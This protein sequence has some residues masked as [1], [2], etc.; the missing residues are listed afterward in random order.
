MNRSPLWKSQVELEHKKIVCRSCIDLLMG[1]WTYRYTERY[2]NLSLG[3]QVKLTF[4]HSIF[5]KRSCEKQIIFTKLYAR[6]KTNKQCIK[7]QGTQ[8]NI[9]HLSEHAG[10]AHIGT[11]TSR[12]K[13][14]CQPVKRVTI[15]HILNHIN[16]IAGVPNG[17]NS[18][19]YILST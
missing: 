11:H 12:L 8:H 7:R 16:H 9:P 3:Y 4:W 14:I 13:Q 10:G 18:F 19:V 1:Q 15:N 5:K 17:S 6:E 2:T